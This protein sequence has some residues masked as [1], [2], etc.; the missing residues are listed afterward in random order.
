LRSESAP[1]ASRRDDALV[2]WLASRSDT[3]Q[4]L[5]ET[6]AINPWG[7]E[8]GSK[9][10]DIITGAVDEVFALLASGQAALAHHDCRR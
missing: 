4:P 8:D 1:V 3:K 9:L 10:D 5:E 6:A 7:K 2:A